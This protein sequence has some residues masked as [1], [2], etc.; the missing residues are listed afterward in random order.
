MIIISPAVENEI[1]SPRPVWDGVY[2]TRFN[3]YETESDLIFRCPM[4]GVQLI[5]IETEVRNGELIIKGKVRLEWNADSKDSKPHCF[6]RSFPVPDN[7]DA[8]R[9][10]AHFQGG[11]LTVRVP[12]SGGASP[13][14]NSNERKESVL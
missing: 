6:Y 8:D 4:P 2:F 10:K 5:Q 11:V 13:L 3:T 7:V 1:R 14:R 12:M 9:I